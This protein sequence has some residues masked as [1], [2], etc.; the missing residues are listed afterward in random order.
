MGK[1]VAFVLT[2]DD[3]A[4]TPAVTRG[5]LALLERGAISATGAMTN[6]PHW[7]EA[8][9]NLSAFAGQADLGLH[10]NLTCGQPLTRMARLCPTGDL[11]KLPRL[12][13]AGLAGRLPLDEIAGEIRAQI[14]AFEDQTGRPPDFIDG[15]QHVHAL[16]GVRRALAIALAD[17]FAQ[18]RPYLR[19]PADSAAAIGARGRQWRKARLLSVLARP[20]AAR[21][22][23][24][25]FALNRGFAGYSAFDPRAD[26]AT[27]FASYL[28]APGPAHLVMCHPGGVDDALRALDPAVE[29][30]EQELAF[31]SSSRFREI[32]AE[33]GL[34]PARF[35]AIHA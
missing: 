7:R 10:L 8:A 12:L 18:T 16:P 31:F 20:F 17:A 14:A 34:T 26:Y 19:D 4:M 9:R 25:G 22:Q 32:C 29:S 5:I 23:A 21:M 1:R 2:A 6:R 11:P 33:A 13:A 15:H 35:A 28:V 27:D 3:Y 30:R 24:L